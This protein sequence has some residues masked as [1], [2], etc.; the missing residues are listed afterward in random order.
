MSTETVSPEEIENT[1][2]LGARN[3]AELLRA[4]ERV[5]QAHA[6]A[7]MG[8]HPSTISR[9]VAS[10]QE[11]MPTLASIGLQLS[12]VGAMVVDPHELTALESMALKY[13]ETRQQQRIKGISI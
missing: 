3:V 2:M 8:V 10:L 5:T 13:L 9:N 1:R 12:P 7:C 4:S 6:A 11:L